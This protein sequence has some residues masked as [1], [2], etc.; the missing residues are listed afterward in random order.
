MLILLATFK[1]CLQYM[2]LCRLRTA[3]ITPREFA[4]STE[5]THICARTN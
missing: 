1:R 3:F 4:N 5:L 2:Y